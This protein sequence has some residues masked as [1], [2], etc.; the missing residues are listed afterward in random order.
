MKNIFITIFIVTITLI[1]CKKSSTFT[2]DCSG[3]NKSFSS[4]VKSIISTSCAT[5]SSCHG[6][7]S[8]RGCGPLTTYAEIYSNR[9]SVSSSV[10]SGSMPQGSS[11]SSTQKNN[12]VC[13]VNQG[14]ANN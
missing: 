6:A 3:S 9:N 10:S 14:A 12:I 7:G 2:S 1:A 11:L 4:D 13:W 8:T 5:G